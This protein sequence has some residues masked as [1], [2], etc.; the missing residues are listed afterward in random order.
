MLSR[1]FLL[2][3]GGAAGGSGLSR[4]DSSRDGP[5]RRCI[6]LI[7][8]CSTG[9]TPAGG[10]GPVLLSSCC[11]V[12]IVLPTQLEKLKTEERLRHVQQLQ[13]QGHGH[14][15][16]LGQRSEGDREGGGWFLLFLP[17][18]TCLSSCLS[19]SQRVLL[20]LSPVS[21]GSGAGC[22]LL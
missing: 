22:F 8:R 12:V 5:K 13:G 9:E 3:G 1:Q 14:L 2:G 17:P 21:S 6:S 4:S 19:P 16:P 10:A 11:N 18:M 15:H 20:A 7:S